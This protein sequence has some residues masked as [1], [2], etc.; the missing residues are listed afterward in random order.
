MTKFSH[1]PE[2]VKV[3]ISVGQLLSTGL[4]ISFTITLNVQF[5]DPFIFTTVTIT[6]VVPTLKNVP[7]LCE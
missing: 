7:G 5:V 2:A 3:D 4:V 1:V 6:G